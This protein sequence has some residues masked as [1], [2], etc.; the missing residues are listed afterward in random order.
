MK[1]GLSPQEAHRLVGHDFHDLQSHLRDSQAERD[2][3]V[4]QMV[5]PPVD[6][7]RR[8]RWVGWSVLLAVFVGLFVAMC[9]A[10]HAAEPAKNYEI[11]AV[12]ASGAQLREDQPNWVRIRMEPYPT[13]ADCMEAITSIRLDRFIG[14]QSGW[15]LT[16]RQL[17]GGFR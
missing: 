5:E 10:P 8:S 3:P 2:L 7:R 6:P 13:R 17:E 15:R 16:C 9:A 12:R 1:G 14:G 4:M 11:W